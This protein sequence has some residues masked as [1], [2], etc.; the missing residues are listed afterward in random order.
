MGKQ[1][2]EDNGRFLSLEEV[3]T[4]LS[5]SIHTVRRWAST[6]RIPTTK[7]GRRVAVSEADLAEFC[8]Q[9]AR[10]VDPRIAA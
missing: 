1:R 2:L 6:R 8:A 9:R 3:A 7:F 5:L 4:Y 10:P